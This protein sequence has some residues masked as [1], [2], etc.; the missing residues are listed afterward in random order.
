MKI[1][2]GENVLR[3]QE[4][5]I[6]ITINTTFRF[7]S[8][9]N[10]GNGRLELHNRDDVVSGK[11]I[12]DVHVKEDDDYEIKLRDYEKGDACHRTRDQTIKKVL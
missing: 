6:G 2:K 5:N 10:Y 3:D 7:K 9:I 4:T 11:R 8:L 1:I 12:T